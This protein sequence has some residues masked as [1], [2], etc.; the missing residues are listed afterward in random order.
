MSL[1]LIANVAFDVIVTTGNFGSD[2]KTSTAVSIHSNP[3]GTV[4][5]EPSSPA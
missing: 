2:S 5:N 3:L 1:P 4:L